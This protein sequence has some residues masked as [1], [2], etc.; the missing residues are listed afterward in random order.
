[1]CCFLVGGLFFGFLFEC[2]FEVFDIL[3]WVFSLFLYCV[4]CFELFEVV[5][6]VFLFVVV[7]W[8]LSVVFMV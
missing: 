5:N 1:M 4:V 8:S 7:D 3:K 2:F 6:Y